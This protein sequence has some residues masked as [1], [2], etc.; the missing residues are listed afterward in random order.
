MKTIQNTE[1]GE[2]LRKADNIAQ[3]YVSGKHARL[4]NWVYVP[5]SVYKQ[6]KEW[7]KIKGDKK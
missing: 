4:K 7:K 3:K 1:T 5:K 2:V 6:I